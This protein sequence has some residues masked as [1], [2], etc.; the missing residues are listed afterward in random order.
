VG[1]EIKWDHQLLAYADDVN[2]FGDNI[3]T[4][5]KNI[6]TLADDSNKGGLE[7][8]AEGTKYMLLFRHLNAGQNND[9]KKE[10]DHLKT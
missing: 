3:G 8:N 6:E 2:L 1:T 10:T 9:I 5:K 4:I 7:E